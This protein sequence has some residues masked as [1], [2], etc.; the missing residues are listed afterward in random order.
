MD[1]RFRNNPGPESERWSEHEKWGAAS[2]PVLPNGGV[3]LPTKQSRASM[4]MLPIRSLRGRINEWPCY[5]C[6]PLAA[7]RSRTKPA[8]G[9]MLP[10]IAVPAAFLGE[11]R[12]Q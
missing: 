12:C 2:K 7:C 10:T 3:P 9:H 11:V 4:D 5:A 6:Y 1:C 8:T